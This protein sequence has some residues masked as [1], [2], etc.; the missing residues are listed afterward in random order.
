[1]RGPTR[2]QKD[3]TRYALRLQAREGNISVGLIEIR[4]ASILSAG[5]NS[6]S[7][8]PSLYGARARE[9]RVA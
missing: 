3:N 9:I 1:M 6:A 4:Y 2:A 8:V 7:R 5:R